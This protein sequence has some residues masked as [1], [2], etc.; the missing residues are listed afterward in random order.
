ME[1]KDTPSFGATASTP[2]NEG[3]LGVWVDQEEKGAFYGGAVVAIK[4][5]GT[6][7][8]PGAV[9]DGQ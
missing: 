3:F 1:P 7:L 9:K 5:D 4:K 6:W 8:V 2:I